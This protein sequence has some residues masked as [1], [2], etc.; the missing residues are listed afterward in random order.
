[1]G[2]GKLLN[3]YLYYKTIVLYKLLK[4]Y[5]NQMRLRRKEFFLSPGHVKGYKKVSFST[6]GLLG[7]YFED[8]SVY[9]GVLGYWSYIVMRRKSKSPC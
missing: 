4:P 6:N 1:M 8:Q 2:T 9:I 5:L 7:S 3:K